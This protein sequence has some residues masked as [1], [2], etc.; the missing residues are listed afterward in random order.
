VTSDLSV[1][2]VYNPG[3]DVLRPITL[4]RCSNQQL[5]C[6]VAESALTRAELQHRT[7]S[8]LDEVAAAAA[9]GE[10]ARIR[11]ISDAISKHFGESED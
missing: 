2:L 8:A 7:L 4:L 1:F 3:P 10:L 11:A 9:A 5:V 6:Q